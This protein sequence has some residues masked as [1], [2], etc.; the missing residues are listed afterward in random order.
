V[1]KGSGRKGVFGAEFIHGPVVGWPSISSNA[2]GHQYRLFFV[3]VFIGVSPAF[4]DTSSG[5]GW[6]FSSVGAVYTSRFPVGC[7]TPLRGAASSIAVLPARS[8]P[9][10]VP[11]P[12]AA[13]L[14]G[15]PTPLSSATST[16]VLQPV[17][18]GLLFHFLPDSPVVG[19]DRNV[20][21]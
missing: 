17:R 12:S 20:I 7:S 18:S 5:P 16:R 3:I 1:A 11:V 8:S 13:P 21:S 9:V 4:P 19:S 6:V 10:A 14:E 2:L 15:Y